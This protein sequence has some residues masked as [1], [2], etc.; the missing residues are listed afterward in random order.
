MLKKKKEAGDGKSRKVFPR[1]EL[2]ADLIT[3][4]WVVMAPGRG[5]SVADISSKLPRPHL[6]PH[7]QEGC[8]LCN[9]RD[10][11]QKPDTLRLPDSDE[12]WLVHI[13]GNKYPAFLPRDEFRAWSEGPYRAMESVGYHEL[14]AT[15]EHHH[16]EVMMTHDQLTILLEAL[17]LRYRQLKAKPSVNYIQIIRNHGQAA[18]GS[19]EH[20][21]H[22]IFTLPVLP[23]DVSAA[24]RG[25]ERYAQ[26]HNEEVFEAIL[27]H[28]R[29]YQR[30]L[31]WENEDYT[32]FCPY[33]SKVPL[34]TWIVPRRPQPFFEDIAPR[35]LES[36]AEAL[37]QILRR[38][39]VGFND[40]HY[41]Y[42]IHSAPCDDTGFVCDRSTFQHFRWHIEITPRF[43]VLFGG[44]ELGT[45]LIINSTL[46]EDA[47][48]YLRE[49][50]ISSLTL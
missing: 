14:L 48:A 43:D 4:E 46:P 23:N 27:R 31:V 22:Q 7:Y 17:V 29:D 18:A 15:R 21:H 45:G 39:Y 30:R 2:R 26:Q 44:F 28:E 13:F 33:A 1:G 42:F 12:D 11:P 35:E 10:F 24:L 20:P 6:R 49:V 3:G 34:E 36:L 38:L 41:N 8:P 47:A 25:A 19:L 40:I 16:T 32:V 37:Q 9:L 5:D 50:D